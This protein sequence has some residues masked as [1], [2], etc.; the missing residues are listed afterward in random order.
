MPDIVAPPV[1]LVNPSCT[2]VPS[3]ISPHSP[4]DFMPPADAVTIRELRVYRFNTTWN[5]E[6]PFALAQESRLPFRDYVF[7]VNKVFPYTLDAATIY[8][9]TP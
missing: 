6:D 1:P 7:F 3:Q 5:P 2:L 9:G 8:V 4:F